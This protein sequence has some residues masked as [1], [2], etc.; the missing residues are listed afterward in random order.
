M[1]DNVVPYPGLTTHNIHPDKV[2]SG[3]I[4]ELQDAIVAGIDMDGNEYFASSYGSAADT[5]FLL[6]RF[7]K[8][9]LE[10]SDDQ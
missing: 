10:A 7:K 1:S 9:L 4:G 3:A 5:L 2:L 8:M 6:E